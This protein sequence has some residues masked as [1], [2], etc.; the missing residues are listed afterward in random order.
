MR[1][2]NTQYARDNKSFGLTTLRDQHVRDATRTI[3]LRF[4]GKSG[5]SHDVHVS[6]RRLASLI[7]RCRDLPGQDLF[8]Y[9]ND[10]GSPSPISSSDVNSYLRDISVGDFTAKDFRTLAGTLFGLRHLLATRDEDV[11]SKRSPLELARTV[12]DALGNTVAVCRKC[13][14][15]PAI[16]G[17]AGDESLRMRVLRLGARTRNQ[18]KLLLAV[19]R[20]AIAQSARRRAA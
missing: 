2:G 14:I 3:R 15:H 7:R 19:L 8:Q 16:M 12:S 6:D 20:D 9:L 17:A 18:E 1:V 4:K 5:V 11:H 10:D 13:Y